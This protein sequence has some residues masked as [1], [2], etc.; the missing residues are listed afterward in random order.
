M[1][2]PLWHPRVGQVPAQALR[3]HRSSG[4]TCTTPPPGESPEQQPQAP[5]YRLCEKTP[6]PHAPV[7]SRPPDHTKPLPCT[8]VPLL[9]GCNPPCRRL[10]TLGG[11]VQVALTAPLTISPRPQLAPRPTPDPTQ[12]TVFSHSPTSCCRH[13]RKPG[14]T[15]WPSPGGPGSLPGHQ[16]EASGFLP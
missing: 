10:E 11:A 9:S 14:R 5:S 16:G 3:A 8:L 6:S 2:G 13:L 7:T 4:A 15:D 12:R 1:W